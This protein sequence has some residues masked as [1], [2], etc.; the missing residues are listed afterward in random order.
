MKDEFLALIE[1]REAE[2]EEF[3]EEMEWGTEAEIYTDLVQKGYTVKSEERYGGEG[4]GD[5]YWLV[6]SVTK[7]GEKKYF[8]LDGWYTSFS[9]HEFDQG[10]LAFYEVKPVEVVVKEWKEA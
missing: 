10:Y 5:D 4:K 2:W 3:V 6:F 9:G 8:R 7:D 1:P